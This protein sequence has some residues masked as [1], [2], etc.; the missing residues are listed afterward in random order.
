MAEAKKITKT[1]RF[2][3]EQF[4]VIYRR[5]KTQ[6]EVAADPVGRFVYPAPATR[7]VVDNGIR[8]E[9]DVAVL[10]RDGT[11]IYIDVYRPA[12][13]TA[14]VPAIVSWSP[15]GKFESYG[16]RLQLPI[17]VPPGTISSM[18]KFE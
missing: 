5:A 7:V 10:L 16:E 4:D 14:R 8:K 11:M 6:E 12:D 18:A 1:R 3:K 9:I 13:S 2:G 15:Y 17:G